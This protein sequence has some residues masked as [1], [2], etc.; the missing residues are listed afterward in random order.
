LTQGTYDEIISQTNQIF[1]EYDTRLTVR[2]IY[3]RLVSVQ[4]ITNDVKSYK[5]LVKILT[6]A[7][8]DSDIDWRKIEDRRRSTIGGDWGFG[9]PEHWSKYTLQYL[10]NNY[11]EAMWGNQDGRI[12]I[13]VEKEAL[14]SLISSVADGFK[15]ITFPTVGYGSF[16]TY[17]ESVQRFQND[18]SG[19]KVTILDFR[20]HDPSGMD[21]SRD[22]EDRLIRYGMDSE[23]L[24]VERIALTY[25][26][27]QEHSLS[28]NPTKTLDPRANDYISEFGNECWE[29]DALPP[30]V[31]QDLVRKA[32]E[33]NLDSELWNEQKNRIARIKRLLADRVEENREE[34][35]KIFDRLVKGLDEAG[36]EAMEGEEDNEE[37]NEED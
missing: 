30:D 18:Y 7:R 10:G 6:K 13:W 22:T 15:V 16:T 27:V 36:D 17:M 25:D 8:E 9:D 35:K 12:E 19:E 5:R 32:I 37:E 23:N 33:D 1:T 4:T 20:D 11:I 24:T 3:Y 21:M 2:Q 29:L 28:P 14:A 34:L 26:Q 31:L